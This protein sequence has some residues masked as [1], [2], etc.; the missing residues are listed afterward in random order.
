MNTKKLPLILSLLIGFSFMATQI[1]FAVD[2]NSEL[3]PGI[4]KHDEIP[5]KGSHKGWEQ[6][7]HKG[8]D[9]DKAKD[10]DRDG[11]EGKKWAKACGAKSKEGSKDFKNCMDEMKA[12]HRQ[13]KENWKEQMKSKHNKAMDDEGD[14]DSSEH[15][16]GANHGGGDHGGGHKGK[17]K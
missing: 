17:S 3:P 9:K 14:S 16:K 11:P 5:G 6:G 7:K 13:E 10:D 12:K 15:G 4:K 8:W 2:T 1:T